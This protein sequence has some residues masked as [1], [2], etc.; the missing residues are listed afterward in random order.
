MFFDVLWESSHLYMGSG[1][2][3][4]RDV[5]SGVAM[6]SGGIGFEIYAIDDA[7]PDEA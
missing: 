4:D 3:L 7:L 5:L 2:L 1:P 6:L